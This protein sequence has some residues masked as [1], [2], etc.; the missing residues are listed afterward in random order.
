[1][2]RSLLA[3]SLSAMLLFSV[4]PNSSLAAAPQFDL[5]IKNGRII[6]GSGR[7][8]YIADLAVT[9]DRIM[10]IG[11]L[12][13]A[14]AARV[15]DAAGMVVSPGFID[16]LGQSESYILID[17]RAMSKVMMGVTTEV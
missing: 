4:A 16:M 6:D 12:K 8:G 5:L 10:R 11:K 17:P 14:K 2:I 3:L 7:R 9:G 13:N 15:I 1:M